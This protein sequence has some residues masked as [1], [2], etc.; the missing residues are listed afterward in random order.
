MAGGFLG[1]KV[2]ENII[3]RLSPEAGAGLYDAIASVLSTK[4]PEE[5]KNAMKPGKDTKTSGPT[6]GP[7]SGPT[8][9]PTSGPISGPISGPT[10]G[11]T[12]G[13]LAR[14]NR[15]K[16]KRQ[17]QNLAAH[18]SPESPEQRNTVRPRFIAAG[19]GPG[20][21]GAQIARSVAQTQA[22]MGGEQNGIVV[23][24][25]NNN[26]AVTNPTTV[27]QKTNVVMEGLSTIAGISNP[28]LNPT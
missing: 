18:V 7:I 6:S 12:S 9:G 5:I 4:S 24:A 27:I 23:G 2:V 22:T 21:I 26:N 15:N 25:I 1:S 19:G 14:L 28:G 13:P 10:S 20:Q 8:S 3:G 16:I 11:P 17:E